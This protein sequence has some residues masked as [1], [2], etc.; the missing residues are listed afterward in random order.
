[1]DKQN[2]IEQETI[3]EIK[4]PGGKV[5]RH[6]TT[7]TWEGKPLCP[8]YSEFEDALWECLFRDILEPVGEP[9]EGVPI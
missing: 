9:V 8:F 1:M 5:L 7:K 4:T 3:I 2:N 6:W